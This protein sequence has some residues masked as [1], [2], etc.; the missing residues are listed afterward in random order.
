MKGVN[1]ILNTDIYAITRSAPVEH[2]C[3]W[4]QWLLAHNYDAD[5]VPVVAE[6]ANRL[7]E[8]GIDLSDEGIA[9]AFEAYFDRV[10]TAI[11]ATLRKT[12][13]ANISCP[14][15]YLLSVLRN[16]PKNHG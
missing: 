14:K 7:R 5:I 1:D 16:Q 10:E 6:Y 13:V 9:Q 4:E 12:E 15:N 2:E 11:V 3:D 8:I